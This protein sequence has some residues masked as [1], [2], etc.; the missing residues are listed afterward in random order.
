[1]SDSSPYLF[2]DK[3]SVA[4]GVVAFLLLLSGLIVFLRLWTRATIH[5]WGVD[6][7]TALLALVGFHV[8]RVLTM[9]M[10]RYGLGRHASTLSAEDLVLYQR[11]FFVSLFLYITTLAVVKL[12]FLFQY[13]RIMSVSN[14][15]V[16]YIAMMVLVA[17]WG[18]GQGTF[19]L[20]ACIPL[21]GFW[22]PNIHAKCV[23]IAHIA[24]YISALFNMFTD[25]II[26][27][28]PLPVIRKLNLPGSQ[29]AFLIGIFSIGFLTV[30]ISAMRIKFLTLLPDP[31]W[32]NFEPVLWSLAELTSAITCASLATP[33]PLLTRLGKRRARISDTESVAQMVASSNLA[34]KSFPQV[35]PSSSGTRETV[36]ISSNDIKSVTQKVRTDNWNRSP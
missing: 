4:Y 1:M 25:I 26:M 31:T 22:D 20:V 9:G 27:I 3:S 33:R 21:E 19:A 8:C 24:W 13:Y 18:I 6:D 2:E 29:K 34:D 5:Q 35:A 36:E 28:L 32:S 17:V 16:V 14:M 23:P 15:R 11:A 10:T 30:A 7:W 12:V